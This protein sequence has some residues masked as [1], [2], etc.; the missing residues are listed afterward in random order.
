MLNAQIFYQL[1]SFNT[2]NY[3]DIKKYNCL[4]TYN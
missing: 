1:S 4:L 2:D 3:A